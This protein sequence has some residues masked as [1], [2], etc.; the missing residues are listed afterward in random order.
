MKLIIILTCLVAGVSLEEILYSDEADLQRENE[1][2]PEDMVNAVKLL[3]TLVTN[4]FSESTENGNF[5]TATLKE[6]ISYLRSIAT[7]VFLSDNEEKA[8]RAVS[9][10]FPEG[11]PF[12]KI[13]YN[14]SL[15]KKKFYWSHDDLRKMKVQL[16]Q[17]QVFWKKA[18][19]SVFRRQCKL[20]PE[21]EIK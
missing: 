5:M 21:I 13:K 11:P 10:A 14:E 20:W 2:E 3:N 1:L 19:K 18:Y 8:F 7:K 17:V 16:R 9:N 4:G 12:F 15:I 6:Y